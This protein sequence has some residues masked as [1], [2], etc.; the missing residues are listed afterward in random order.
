MEEDKAKIAR[1]FAEVLKMTAAY[2]DLRDLTYTK[3][4][5]SDEFVLVEFRN[6]RTKGINVHWDSGIAMI[7]DIIRGLE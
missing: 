6:G 4:A 5:D 3:T 7:K 1:S 2:K